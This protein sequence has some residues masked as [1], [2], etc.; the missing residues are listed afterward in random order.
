MVFEIAAL[1]QAFVNKYRDIISL[2]TFIDDIYYINKRTM[3]LE[4]IGWKYYNNNVAK[5][6][7]SKIIQFAKVLRKISSDQYHAILMYI[8]QISEKS[9]DVTYQI[10]ETTC[11][12]CGATIP[13]T[14]IAGNDLVFTRHQLAALAVL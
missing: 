7:K 1:D 13:A 5:T 12:E 9:D 2:I 4:P 14:P 10:P 6:T 3:Q 8:Q 11:P